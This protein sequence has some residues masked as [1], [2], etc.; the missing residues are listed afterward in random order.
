[1]GAPPAKSLPKE[2]KV[3]RNSERVARLLGTEIVE[4]DKKGDKR[5]YLSFQ[6]D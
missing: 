6:N 5:V 2:V 1:V 4:G 3:A